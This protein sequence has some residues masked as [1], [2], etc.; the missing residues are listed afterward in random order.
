MHNPK[1][2]IVVDLSDHSNVH[3]ITFIEVEC[4][5]ILRGDATNTV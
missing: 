4:E 3:K 5:G 1:G 2:V